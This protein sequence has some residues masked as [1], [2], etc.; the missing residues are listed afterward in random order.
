M[1]QSLIISLLDRQ[2]HGTGLSR[3]EVGELPIDALNGIGT[4]TRAVLRDMGI[5][6]IADLA[7]SRHF[8]TARVLSS[9]VADRR[10]LRPGD[11]DPSVVRDAGPSIDRDSPITVLPAVGEEMAERIS[12]TL[13]ASTVG[14]LADSS[15][16]RA[17]TELVASEHSASMAEVSAALDSASSTALFTR[18]GIPDELVPTMHG[19]AVAQDYFFENFID[20][21]GSPDLREERAEAIADTS[22]EIWR[23]RDTIELDSSLAHSVLRNSELNLDEESMESMRVMAYS[24]TDAAAELF[25]PPFA[26][27]DLANVPKGFEDVAFGGRLSFRRELRPKGVNL[28]RLLHSVTLAPG[29]S[30]NIAITDWT[31]SLSTRAQEAVSQKEAL[32]QSASDDVDK[33]TSQDAE[34]AEETQGKSTLETSSTTD[35]SGWAAGAGI[36]GGAG[37]L[38]VGYSSDSST[39]TGHSTMTTSS[40]SKRNLSVRGSE[41]ISRDTQQRA[42]SQREKMATAVTEVREAGSARAETRNITNYNHMHALSLHYYEVIQIY[43][44]RVV[45]IKAEPLIF[46][47]TKLL[48]LSDPKLVRRYKREIAKAARSET[49]RALLGEGIVG[50]KVQLGETQRSALTTK[51]IYGATQEILRQMRRSGVVGSLIDTE[52]EIPDDFAFAGIDF[53]GF[54]T[55]D[56]PN[57]IPQSITI[58]LDGGFTR[59]HSVKDRGVT[60]DPPIR[61]ADI[62]SVTYGPTARRN[63]NDVHMYDLDNDDGSPFF[64]AQSWA[65]FLFTRGKLNFTLPVVL[66]TSAQ[67]FKGTILSFG[68]SPRLE[69]A[70][71]I[72][73]GDPH[74]YSRAIWSSLDRNSI[75]SLLQG[76]RFDGIDLSL[77]VDPVIVAEYANMI[78]MPLAIPNENE[79]L[80]AW[81]SNWRARNYDEDGVVSDLVAVPTGGVH[82]EAILGRSNC[83][84]FLDI[85]R[86]W[87]WQESPIPN[88]APEIAAANPNQIGTSATAQLPSGLEAPIINLQNIPPTPGIDLSGITAAIANGGMF[89]D[90]SG[91]EYLTSAHSNALQFSAA[92]ARAAGDR[93]TALTKGVFELAAVQ[94][95]NSPKA[96]T[97]SGFGA[98]FNALGS[99]GGAAAG[100][101]IGTAIGGPAGTAIGSAVGGAVGGAIGDAAADYVSND[102]Q[103][104]A[105]QARIMPANFLGETFAAMLPDDVHNR[106]KDEGYKLLAYLDNAAKPLEIELNR[107]ALDRLFEDKYG[108]ID[109]LYDAVMKAAVGRAL[110]EDKSWTKD[111]DNTTYDEAAS[112]IE[113]TLP[114]F[115]A[116]RS[117]G[118]TENDLSFAHS[119]F[120]RMGNEAGLHLIKPEDFS[121]ETTTR[122][123]EKGNKKVA[124]WS[125]LTISTFLSALGKDQAKAV[126][127]YKAYQHH[128]YLGMGYLNRER[129]DLTKPFWIYANSEAPVMIGSLIFKTRGSDPVPTEYR[130]IIGH[131]GTKTHPPLRQ[132]KVYFDSLIDGLADYWQ[133]GDK[134][135]LDSLFKSQDGTEFTKIDARS[136]RTAMHCDLVVFVGKIEGSEGEMAVTIGGNTADSRV[137]KHV[138][139]VGMKFYKLDENRRVLGE[140]K[141]SDLTT[142]QNADTSFA[143]SRKP[144]REDVDASLRQNHASELQKY[145]IEEFNK[146]DADHVE[147]VINSRNGDPVNSEFF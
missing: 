14:E 55:E 101:A 64:M 84:E 28:G 100:G 74:Y 95:K 119:R 118:Y 76:R 29:E 45:P 102:A 41:K 115:K 129:Q 33:E 53:P 26:P 2:Y 138:D 62:R 135:K 51:S 11:L 73:A 110:E 44:Q 30:T 12:V 116:T 88:L 80:T 48:D 91:Q 141:G 143:I 72:I 108:L 71:N 7:A 87:D 75:L 34:A 6:T 113:G 92:N 133:S 142:P 24:V 47:P 104:S 82:S 61:I 145:L 16:Y 121:I 9:D 50:Q 132:R 63:Q 107:K 86:F 139:T 39:S 3:E 85:R 126:G 83:A 94:A 60:I 18:D 128:K 32:E 134:E 99:K 8:A 19:Y 140:V 109:K 23:G 38:G 105:A 25:K 54:P 69:E 22:P 57:Q 79:A 10:S 125:G 111:P 144:L 81:W 59:K 67:E 78:G 58:H 43:E 17:A 66:Q 96:G 21:F 5:E 89:R 90:M 65:L 117:A 13:G 103:R 146:L 136:H 130:T 131:E 27:L 56:G 42:S 112:L 36:W 120:R 123:D 137:D 20:R 124:Y 40:S 77:A 68:S 98:V 93:A 4:E 97:N 1:R 127:F 52:V 106:L 122:R 37:V 114:N 70:I 147:A 31:R 46:L 49:L 15:V 35:S